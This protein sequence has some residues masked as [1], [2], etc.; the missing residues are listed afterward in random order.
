MNRQWSPE[1]A[2][3]LRAEL[4]RANRKKGELAVVL[5]LSPAAVTRRVSGET[6]LDID[7]LCAVAAW[8]DI[9]ITR[10]LPQ[11]MNPPTSGLL[12]GSPAVIDYATAA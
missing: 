1:T 9:P 8:L 3:N 7:E 2:S 12:G 11:D 4:A 5:G 10:L 6:A